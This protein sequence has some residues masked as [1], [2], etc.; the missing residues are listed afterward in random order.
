MQ[1]VQLVCKREYFGTIKQVVMNDEWTAVLSEGKVT[2]HLIE[3]NKGNDR[4]FPQTDQDKPVSFISLIDSFLLLVDTLGKLKY[5]LIEDNTIISEHRSTNPV[6]KVFPNKKGTKCVCIDNT[7]NGYVFCPVDDTMHF[8]PNFSAGTENVLWDLEDP[9][10]FVTV[11]REKMQTYLYIPLSLDG[12]QILHLPEYLKLEEIEKT[13]PGV[14]TYVDKDLKPIILKGGFVYSHAKTDGIRGQ[15]L[16]THSYINSWRGAQET[17]EG[18]LRYFLQCLAI[19]RY[20]SCMDAARTCLRYSQVFFEALGKQC[21]KYIDLE[22]AE[23]AFQMCKNV[24]MVYSIQ[25]IKNESEKF[26]LMGHVASILFKHDLAQDYF[27]KSSKREL[28]LEM[29]MDLQD[30]FAALK[31][32]KTIAP[33]KE[34]FIC[35]KLAS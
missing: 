30:W 26:I 7:G 5:Y 2:L 34:Q 15:F 3:D 32:C 20:H 13:K 27:M 17:D 23:V 8:I 33:E 9:N 19:Q 4:R 12:T 14:I 18:H 6:V 1:V 24:G 21:L 25:S 10:I 31:L 16:T 29:R 22:A 11:D 35:R 28:A